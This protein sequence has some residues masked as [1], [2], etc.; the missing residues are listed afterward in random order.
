MV[1]QIAGA[2]EYHHNVALEWDLTMRVF[3]RW[4]LHCNGRYG[5]DVLITGHKLEKLGRLRLQIDLGK[6]YTRPHLQ[7]IQ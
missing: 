5:S 4:K 2:A 3:L 1:S 7:S 6:S